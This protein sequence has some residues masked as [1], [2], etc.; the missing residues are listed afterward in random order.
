MMNEVDTM[1]DGARTP[2]AGRHGGDHVDFGDPAAAVHSLILEVETLLRT[3]RGLVAQARGTLTSGELLWPPQR[4]SEVREQQK[5][6]END[7]R[8]RT[9]S[10]ESEADYKRSWRRDDHPDFDVDLLQV[11]KS[12]LP[13][14]SRAPL[15]VLTTLLANHGRIVSNSEICKALGTDSPKIVKVYVCRLRRL[16]RVHGVDVEISVMKGGYGVPRDC[17]AFLLSG[18]GFTETQVRVILNSSFLGQARR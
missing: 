15:V 5:E 12:H 18:L 1:V 2:P 6:L 8:L 3:C 13:D 4:I 11:F 17:P 10:D 7:P 16:F 14:L 9:V